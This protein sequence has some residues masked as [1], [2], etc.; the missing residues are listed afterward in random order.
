[1]LRRPPPP[2]PEVEAIFSCVNTKRVGRCTSLLYQTN[3]VVSQNFWCRHFHI[4][5]RPGR[6]QNWRGGS[7]PPKLFE[8]VHLQFRASS[9]SFSTQNSY[10]Y[11]R[12][13][14][15]R[16]EVEHCAF[17]P[18]FAV[19]GVFT[20]GRGPEKFIW[21]FIYARFLE[22]TPSVILAISESIWGF[23]I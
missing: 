11:R 7:V 9:R 2:P 14:C 22:D 3:M 5:F 6:H 15:L 21:S 10:F 16:A 18:H 8:Q 19:S 1:M 4:I 17:W 12:H 13:R 20:M 23:Y